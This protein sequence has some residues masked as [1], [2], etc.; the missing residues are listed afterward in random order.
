MGDRGNIFVVQKRDADERAIGVYLYTHW[1]GYRIKQVAAEALSSPAGRARRSD[2]AYL[3]R[4][5]FDVLTRGE[6][7][8]ETGYGISAVMEDNEYPVVVIDAT[9]GRAWLSPEG[10][11]REPGPEAATFDE[12]VAEVMAEA[13]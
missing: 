5:I 12:F 4:I 6:Q 7:G 2:P 1:S 3:T 8:G 11:E 13:T 9:C 10:C